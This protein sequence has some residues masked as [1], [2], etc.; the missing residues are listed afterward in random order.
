MPSRVKTILLPSE[1]NDMC[2]ECLWKYAKLLVC[3]HILR[4]L[5]SCS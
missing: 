4:V 3:S 5:V 1:S 2:F